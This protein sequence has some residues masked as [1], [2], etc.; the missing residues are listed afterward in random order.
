MGY[1]ALTMHLWPSNYSVSH[2]RLKHVPSNSSNHHSR[3][4]LIELTPNTDISSYQRCFLQTPANCL[5][6]RTTISI[7][8]VY[9]NRPLHRFQPEV[10]SYSWL[11][12]LLWMADITNYVIHVFPWMHYH[13]NQN[14]NCYRYDIFS[15]VYANFDQAMC[16]IWRESTEAA[17][18]YKLLNWPRF[19]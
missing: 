10:D 18:S 16:K 6:F 9:K 14:W 7:I 19:V 4:S 13:H 15:S 5:A 3:L 8:V 1:V 17:L 12:L 2:K 11:Q